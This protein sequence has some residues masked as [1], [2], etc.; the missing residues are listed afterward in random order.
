MNECMFDVWK[1]FRVVHVCLDY[2][3]AKTASCMDLFTVQK[4][5][6]IV[7]ATKPS[8]LHRQQPSKGKP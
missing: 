2:G 5:S 6:V 4:R 8:E 7:S 3:A 1:K